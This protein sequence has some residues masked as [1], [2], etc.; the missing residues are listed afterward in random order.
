ML[1]PHVHFLLPIAKYQ[2]NEQGSLF[3][4]FFTMFIG[5]TNIQIQHA[6]M[7]TYQCYTDGN[8]IIQLFIFW[9]DSGNGHKVL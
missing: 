4:P 9:L 1:V 6:T 2:T 8:D 7:Y 3:V 5:L